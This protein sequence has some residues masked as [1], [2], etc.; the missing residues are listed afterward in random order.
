M[1]VSMLDPRT[2]LVLVDLQRGITSLPTVSSAEAVVHA[3]GT[4]VRAWHD[5][6]LPVVAVHVEYSPD[7]GDVLSARTDASPPSATATP[8]FAELRPELGLHSSDLTVTKRGW[9][10]FYGTDLDLQLRRR[11]VTG[12]VLAGI[13]TSIGVESTA[14]AAAERGYEIAIASNACTDTNALAHQASIEVILPRL[15]QLDDA[16][17]IIAALRA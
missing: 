17:R 3:A 5:R 9:N 13:S 4:L 8:D 15:G 6:A 10:A 12:L 7:F 14:R 1:P 11:R 2:A 16:D